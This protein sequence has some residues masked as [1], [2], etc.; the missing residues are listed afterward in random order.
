MS[1]LDLKAIH[2]ALSDQ[3]EAGVDDSG[4]F[5]FGAHPMTAD[6]P[7]IEVW[8]DT[9]YIKYYETSGP[10]GLSVVNLIIR[11]FLSGAN[12]ESE[13]LTMCALTSAG[14]GFGSSIADAVMARRDL[15]GVVAT[16]FV[17]DARWD[18]DEGSI[19]IPV[20]V[21]VNKQGAQT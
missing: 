11:C 10:D 5:S 16:T 4:D 14:T 6:R 12:P 1:G 21:R 2:E 18:P 13:W 7:A 9:D 15:G 17:G 20:E 3:I 19:D 8:P